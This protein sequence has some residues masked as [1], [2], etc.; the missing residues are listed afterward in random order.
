MEF[1][2][3]KCAMLNIKRGVQVKSEGITVPSGE[4]IKEVDENR[5]NSA[6]VT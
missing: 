1:G 5:F 3:E 4:L 2:F 6:F